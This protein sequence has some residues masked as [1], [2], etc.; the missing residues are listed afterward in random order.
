MKI[1]LTT[2]SLEGLTTTK[3]EAIPFTNIAELIKAA[4]F[5]NVIKYHSQ[6]MTALANKQGNGTVKYDIHPFYVDT[7]GNLMFRGT[8]EN[9]TVATGMHR[10]LSRL[11]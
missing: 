6:H 1:N 10:I 7:Y 8:G 9:T 3:N 4:N 11:P 5:I 2:K